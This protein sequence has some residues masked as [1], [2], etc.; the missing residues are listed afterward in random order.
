[1]KTTIKDIEEAIKELG[2][3]M[4]EMML[5]DKADSEVKI[6]KAKAQKR[7][8]LAREGIRSITFN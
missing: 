1:M 2:E 8:S 4:T 3:A 5:L 7:L 6:A